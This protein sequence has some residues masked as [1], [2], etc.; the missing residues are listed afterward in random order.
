MEQVFSYADHRTIEEMRL[1]RSY[2]G[3]E[4]FSLFLGRKYLNAAMALKDKKG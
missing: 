1:C 3:P 4:A 2:I